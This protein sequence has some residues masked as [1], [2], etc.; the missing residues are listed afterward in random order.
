MSALKTR[1]TGQPTARVG[2]FFVC[3]LFALIACTQGHLN[4]VSEA[5]L[6]HDDPSSLILAIEYSANDERCSYRVQG[7]GERADDASLVVEAG[8]LKQ[9]MEDGAK[10]GNPFY[11]KVWQSLYSDIMARMNSSEGQEIRKIV[12][13]FV[14]A[15]RTSSASQIDKTAPWGYVTLAIDA[16]T[17]VQKE[18][19]DS[20]RE[21]TIAF[22]NLEDVASKRGG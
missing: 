16:C 17:K 3:L 4:P 5:E 11:T 22:K 1:I 19:K 7:Y 20:D 2:L 10:E 6:V 13:T 15:T 14:K 8:T 12:F 18:L 21:I 9:L